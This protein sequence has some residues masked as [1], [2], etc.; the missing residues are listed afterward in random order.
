MRT[1]FWGVLLSLALAAQTLSSVNGI[2]LG[3]LEAGGAKLRVQIHVS[4]DA[5]GKLACSLDSI[6]QGAS[7]LPCSNVQLAGNRLSF[8]V[9]VVQGHWAG[10]LSGDGNRLSGT[11]TQVGNSL[12]LNLVRQAAPIPVEKAKPPEYDEA[13]APVSLTQIKSVLDKDLAAALKTGALSPDTHGGVAI[14]VLYQGS[15]QVFHYGNAKDDALFEIGSISKTFTGLILACMV[16]QQK[17]SL[18]EPVREL[19]PKGTVPKPDGSEIT[20]LDLATQHSGLPRMPDNFH[21][22][23]P[24]DPYADY[25]PAKLYEFL[26]KKGV[27]KRADAS[28]L[29]S[30]LGFGLLGQALSNRAG[31]N[32]PELLKSEVTDPLGMRDTTVKLSPEQQK[33]FAQGYTSSHQPAHAWNLDAIAGAGAIRSTANDM[34][35]YLQ[36]QLHP[37]S[38]K[39]L[40]KAIE[41]SHQLRADALPGMKIAFAWLYNE[42]TGNYWHNGGTGGFSSFA[43]FSP[44]EDYAA[45]VLFNTTL[46]QNGSFADR[47][48]EHIAE[49]LAGRPAVSLSE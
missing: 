38:H 14:G 42:K 18:D 31:V 15:R 3:T 43:F 19:L 16:E 13:M 27:G 48:G 49:R 9:P 40:R 39:E 34:L 25:G 30:N 37:E 21:P 23:N 26:A 20:L 47:L 28:F 36:A 44:K 11:W 41:M 8:D 29:Y 45:V 7:G 17:V 35:I 5:G 2:W 12:T 24:E 4:T 22:T 33:R 6:D 10:E 32:Y 1:A 46:G